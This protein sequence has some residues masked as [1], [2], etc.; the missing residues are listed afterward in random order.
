MPV[1]NRILIS[2]TALLLILAGCEPEKEKI[3]EAREVLEQNSQDAEQVQ[4][5]AEQP[6]EPAGETETQAQFE[7]KMKVITADKKDVP[8]L[9]EIWQQLTRGY[10]T[11]NR[12]EI[13]DETQLEIAMGW[14]DLPQKLDAITQKL[15]SVRETEMS[16][17][18]AE[19]QPVY[20]KVGKAIDISKFFYF[21]KWYKQ[22]DYQ[23]SNTKKLLKVIP[24]KISERNL[25]N[26]EITIVFS[27]FLKGG[28]DME[29]SEMA[30]G[31]TLM[32]LQPALIGIP[33]E[34]DDY[35][36]NALLT[37]LDKE[38]NYTQSIIILTVEPL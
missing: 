33:A 26:L 36:G 18:A 30:A 24:R 23:F 38:G 16:A 19:Y 14:A 2:I 34:P 6:S 20:L 21:G 4:V 3:P 17:A 9:N 11:A 37:G 8:T 32:P 25:I 27:E 22:S 10:M 7:I 35:L 12:A 31:V 28:G 15:S 29:F 1:M 5:S 13:F